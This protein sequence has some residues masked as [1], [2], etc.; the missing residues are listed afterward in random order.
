MRVFIVYF[1]FQAG[2][3]I[4]LMWVETEEALSSVFSSLPALLSLLFSAF[5]VFSPMM[6]ILTSPSSSMMSLRVTA[7]V[8]MS[9][10]GFW[11]LEAR[12]DKFLICRNKNTSC[13]KNQTSYS[14]KSHCVVCWWLHFLFIKIDST[15]N[16]DSDNQDEHHHHQEASGGG[17]AD[18]LLSLDQVRGLL[19]WA[20]DGSIL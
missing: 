2:S 4:H 16:N 9:T 19:I 20:R 15:N 18:I 14:C 10:S 12:T 13:L 5:P 17:G 8:P 1:S 3:I 7:P 11:G 6:L